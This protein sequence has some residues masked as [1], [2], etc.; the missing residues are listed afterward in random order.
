MD[1][2]HRSC[3]ESC[4]HKKINH[5][6]LSKAHSSNTGTKQGTG[7]WNTGTVVTPLEFVP[8]VLQIPNSHL[9]FRTF[10]FAAIWI[11]MLKESIWKYFPFIKCTFSLPFPVCKNF[12][13]TKFCLFFPSVFSLFLEY[14]VLLAYYSTMQYY[15]CHRKYAILMVDTVKLFVIYIF[16]ADLCVLHF[17]SFSIIQ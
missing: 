17:W 10:W 4:A 16:S 7:M 14:A 5:F 3:S 6:N 9:Q 15:S 12:V 2:V 13:G 1:A 11:Y 8:R